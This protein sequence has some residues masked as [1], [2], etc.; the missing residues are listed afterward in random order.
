MYE[1]C[2][3]VRNASRVINLP[4]S[5]F[6][7]Q[8]TEKL[9]SFRISTVER[10]GMDRDWVQQLYLGQDGR[11]RL[12]KRMKVIQWTTKS[13]NNNRFNI[14]TTQTTR[15][16]KTR[17]HFLIKVYT[18]IGFVNKETFSNLLRNNQTFRQL[19]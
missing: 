16:E 5:S 13:L 14:T 3:S 1:N 12:K 15:D 18:E 6:S 4:S 10:D 7:C 17:K 9:I 2:P 8:L 11:W 19:R